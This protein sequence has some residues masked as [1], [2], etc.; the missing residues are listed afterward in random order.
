MKTRRLRQ[1]HLQNNKLKCISDRA[2][3]KLKARSQCQKIQKFHQFSKFFS[4]FKIFEKF[5][6]DFEHTKSV[7]KF[8]IWRK[9]N[10]HIFQINFLIKMSIL[11]F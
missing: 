11:K 1:L 2:F 3:D 4:K 10:F 8:S 6:S 9:I 7:W 5:K